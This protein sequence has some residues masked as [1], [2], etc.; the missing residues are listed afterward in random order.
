MK[1]KTGIFFIIAIIIINC[2]IAS[3]QNGKVLEAFTKSYEYETSGDYLNAIS[4][5]ENVYE[6]DSYE[7]NVRL[8][9]LNYKAGDYQKSIDYYNKAINLM[10]YSI[11]PKL[12][13]NLPASALKNWDDV[14]SKYKSILEIDPQNTFVHYQLGNIYY[15]RKDFSNAYTS[16][17]KIVNLYP[18]DFDSVLMFAWTNYQM[19]KLREAKVLFGKALLISPSNQSA[20][21][22][23]NLLK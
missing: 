19:G 5:L 12:G 20:S 2:G 11:E 15:E 1:N 10:P 9:W 18:F 14:I 4:A 21:E 17:E 22:G 23:L 8:G 16:F 13:Y 6:A 3:G 7:I